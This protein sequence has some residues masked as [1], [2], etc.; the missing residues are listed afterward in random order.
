MTKALAG[1]VL[2]EKFLLA[3]QE[4]LDF[5]KELDLVVLA[6][7]RATCA[8]TNDPSTPREVVRDSIKYHYGGMQIFKSAFLLVHVISS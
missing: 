2:V 7:L 8:F 3:R 1:P 6:T 4:I 5:E